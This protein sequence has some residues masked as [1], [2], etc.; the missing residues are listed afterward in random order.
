MILLLQQESFHFLIENAKKSYLD[1]LRS[2]RRS[3]K[4]SLPVP[5]EQGGQTQGNRGRDHGAPA[6]GTAIRSAGN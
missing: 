3:L 1:F 4:K 2:R 6:A 5:G